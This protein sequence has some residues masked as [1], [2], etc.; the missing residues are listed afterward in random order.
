MFAPVQI[1]YTKLQ[2]D[3]FPLEKFSKLQNKNFTLWGLIF[4]VDTFKM[5]AGQVTASKKIFMSRFMLMIIFDKRVFFC[6]C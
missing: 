2:N 5:R 6:N 1:S 4:L 3:P